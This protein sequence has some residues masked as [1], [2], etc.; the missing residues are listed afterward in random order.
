MLI[1]AIA[2]TSALTK[3]NN[4]NH[5]PIGNGV[6]HFKKRIGNRWSVRFKSCGSISGFKFANRRIIF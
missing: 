4:R 3:K 2:T 1:N 5:H 6:H